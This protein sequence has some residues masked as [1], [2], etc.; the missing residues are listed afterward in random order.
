MPSSISA[1]AGFG[2]VSALL[3]FLLQTPGLW[4]CPF[5]PE[6]CFDR[7]IASSESGS[8]SYAGAYAVEQSVVQ[9]GEGGAA[10]IYLTFD[11][12]P[13]PEWT[14]QILDL[15][16][17]YGA[18]ATFFVTGWAA[19]AYPALIERIVSEGHTLGNHSWGHENLTTLTSEE[20]QRNLRRT[21]AV[22]GEHA[23]AC[24]RPPYFA[25]N[26]DVRRGAAALGLR[27]VF[28]TLEPQDW[29]RPGADVIAERIVASAYAGSIIVLHDGG[30][31]RSQTV[32]GLALAMDLLSSQGYRFEAVC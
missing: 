19:A 3:V 21:Q 4:S 8:E 23:T 29:T 28:G 17:Q 5:V 20:L 32:A 25:S 6:H 18:R 2:L 15:L 27:L 11:D 10:T 1:V 13:N 9:R 16:S 30:G 14:P 22:L 31:E 7:P 26:D 24:M 12:G